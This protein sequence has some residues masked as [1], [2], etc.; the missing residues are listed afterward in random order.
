M[1]LI[2]FF[3]GVAMP[4]ANKVLAMS[5]MLSSGL[6]SSKPRSLTA[7]STAR[8]E[9]I[10]QPASDML[11]QLSVIW[12]GHTAGS[13]PL[14]FIEEA[15]HELDAQ[16]CA[17]CP[18]V[19]FVPC[20][21]LPYRQRKHCRFKCGCMAPTLVLSMTSLLSSCLTAGHLKSGNALLRASTSLLVG[22]VDPWLTMWRPLAAAI[23][24]AR[25]WAR[26]MSLTSHTHGMRE[27]FVPSSRPCRVAQHGQ[28][29]S[30]GRAWLCNC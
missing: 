2:Y 18:A 8:K 26:A 29:L 28:A 25:M 20:R 13:V 19:C 11:I 27:S 4:R 17:L 5:Q 12:R 14:L 21:V 23:S 3:M 1:L 16:R 6:W 15:C 22:T 24:A 7:C 9:H 10:T 30:I